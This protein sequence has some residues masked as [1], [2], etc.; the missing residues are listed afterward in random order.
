MPKSPYGRKVD[1]CKTTLFTTAGH[2]FNLRLHFTLSQREPGGPPVFVSSF[3]G[4]PVGPPSV[5]HQ[6]V[7]EIEWGGPSLVNFWSL[8]VS[9]RR[10]N[11]LIKQYVVGRSHSHV[12]PLG[13]KIGVNDESLHWN[14]FAQKR[15][16]KSPLL[17]TYRCI[18]NIHYKNVY[19]Q[20]SVYVHKSS[21][22]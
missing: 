8:S 14:L 9:S 12:N 16:A 7:P 13:P 1:T 4:Q 11:L 18:H 2:N 6:T 22:L 20:I 3:K 19:K 5:P 15:D 21:F 17:W 10:S